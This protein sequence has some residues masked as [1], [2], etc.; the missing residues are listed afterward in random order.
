MLRCVLLVAA[1]TAT[2]FAS[3]KPPVI[4][5]NGLAGSRMTAT[6]DTKS[7]PHFFCDRNTKGKSVDLWL[8]VKELVP[9]AIDCLF[10]N[11][12]LRYDSST[13]QYSNKPGVTLDASV[14]FGGVNGLN[15]LDSGVKLSAYFE[16]LIEKLEKTLNY[17]VGKD[18]RGAPFDW[19][20][21]PDGL[22]QSIAGAASSESYFS[23]LKGLVEETVK[24]NDNRKVVFI[25]HSMGGPVALSFLQQQTA[26]WKSTNVAGF[27]PMSP[28][29]GGAVSTVLALVSGDTLGVPIVSHSIFHP[30]QS[31]CASGPW[32]FP[33]PSLW[34]PNEI[35]VTSGN[36]VYT[37]S[38]YT[39]LTSDLGLDQAT[40]L[41]KDGVNQLAL[42]TFNPPN[43]RVEVL[44][45]TGVATPVSY[46]YDDVFVKGK[47][48]S[49]PTKTIHE[50]TGDGTVNDRSLNRGK[51]W[52]AKQSELVRYWE[53]QNTSH[54]GILESDEALDH[55]IS[56]LISFS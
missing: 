2:T 18:L 51:E 35:L 47:V 33:Q 5:L 54:F 14:D 43:V 28:P 52:I 49:A 50:M 23:R 3:T 46:I 27:L 13:K 19:R 7:A 22:G 6:L 10:D 34:S 56:L 20:L 40:N 15:Y 41:F 48:P 29:F 38:N 9:G 42:G 39:Q 44:R 36:S 37:S 17:T 30:I 16:T 53:F 24:Q 4:L 25:T 12:K 1:I 11:M 32:L 21:A 55:I 45:G 26:S 8:S 31:T